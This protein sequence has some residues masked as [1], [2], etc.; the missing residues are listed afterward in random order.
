M[1]LKS[2]V[3]CEL[4]ISTNNTTNK[5][6]EKLV[7]DLVRALIFNHYKRKPLAREKLREVL[8]DYNK[9]HKG[10]FNTL[11]PEVQKRVSDLF[12]FSVIA[13]SDKD[14]YILVNNIKEKE[15]RAT[16]LGNG[17]NSATEGLLSTIISIL[18]LNGGKIEEPILFALLDRLGLNRNNSKHPVFGDWVALVQKFTDQGFRLEMEVKVMFILIKITYTGYL[19]ANSKKGAETDKVYAFGPRISQELDEENLKLF[20]RGVVCSPSSLRFCI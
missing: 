17:K 13:V 2:R 4:M 18:H 19:V 3:G 12:G 5:E 1:L 15:L 10:L 20:I 7:G 14:K 11:F 9:T 6:R 16:I 8:K